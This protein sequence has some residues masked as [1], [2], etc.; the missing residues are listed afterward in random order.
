MKFFVLLF[1]QA[2]CRSTV[3][4]L[5]D[6]MH[7]IL[8]G[9]SMVTGQILDLDSYVPFVFYEKYW[10]AAGMDSTEKFSQ[11][12]LTQIERFYAQLLEKNIILVKFYAQ[13]IRI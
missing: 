7:V 1:V 4:W 3:V 9:N 11:I 5:P 6:R 10:E 8:T 2:Y 13:K 12:T